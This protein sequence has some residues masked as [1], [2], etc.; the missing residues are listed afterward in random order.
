MRSQAVVL[1]EESSD[2]VLSMGY[3]HQ[4]S[5]AGPAPKAKVHL[6]QGA[7]EWLGWENGDGE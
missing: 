2:L 5:F 3:S 7:G 4:L 6:Q 1:K